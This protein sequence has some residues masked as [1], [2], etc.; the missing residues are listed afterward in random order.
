MTDAEL[1]KMGEGIEDRPIGGFNYPAT[2]PMEQCGTDVQRRLA[3]DNKTHIL[4]HKELH[5]YLDELVANF[6]L[7]TNNLPSSTTVMDLMKWSYSQT[8]SPT[9]ENNGRTVLQQIATQGQISCPLCK[10][11]GFSEIYRGPDHGYQCEKCNGKG[12]L[13]NSQCT[14]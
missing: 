14:L 5:K 11:T 2:K 13:Q 3:M 6:L 1:D 12:K 4:R 8:I 7:V 9:T 10:G